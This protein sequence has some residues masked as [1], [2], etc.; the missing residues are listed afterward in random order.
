MAK[1]TIQGLPLITNPTR[2]ESTNI[3]TTLSRLKSS[4]I[5]IPDYQRDAEQWDTR[6][7]SLF[8]ESILNNLTIPAFF[9][10]ERDDGVI[11]VVDGQQRLNTIRKYATDTFKIS[12]DEE[13]IYLTPRVF[14]TQEK[15]LAS[16][17]T[18]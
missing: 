14:I 9:F 4:R 11:E 1:T 8:I 10:S 12:A 5:I 17:P 13:I 18:P 15:S 2:S 7:E 16:C 6:K 3:E